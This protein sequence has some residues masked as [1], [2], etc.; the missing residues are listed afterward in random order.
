[1]SA[2]EHLLPW[3]QQPQEAAEP[4]IPV[5][6]LINLA[7][8]SLAVVNGPGVVVVP[9]GVQFRGNGSSRYA[10]RSVIFPFDWTAGFWLACLF[11]RRSTTPGAATYAIGSNA[12]SGNAFIG[13]R[14]PGAGATNRIEFG[15]RVSNGG[16]F[17]RIVTD[18][19]FTTSV[20]GIYCAVA[21]VPPNSVNTSSAYL[22]VNGVRHA[23]V[24]DLLNYTGTV[25]FGRFETIGAVRRNIGVDQFSDDGVFWAASGLGGI[26][27]QTAQRISAEMWAVFEPRR[28]WVPVSAG[29]GTTI[30]AGVGESTAAGSTADI[31]LGTTV[32]TGVGSAVADGSAASVSRGA[33]V[34]A[35]IGAA[36]AAGLDADIGTSA[37]EY[38]VGNAVA[39][40]ATASISLGTTV[41]ADVSNAVAAGSTAD[42]SLGTT[43]AAGVGNAVADGPSA[44]IT[45]GQTVSATVGDAVADGKTATITNDPVSTGIDLSFYGWDIFPEKLPEEKDSVR[46]Y[47]LDAVRDLSSKPIQKEVAKRATARILPP[48]VFV[49]RNLMVREIRLAVAEIVEAANEER[50]RKVRK[51]N[52]TIMLWM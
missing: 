21:V 26:D 13:L 25:A 33:T 36:V 52:E 12:S 39:D 35:S 20:G 23:T 49:P 50:R 31:S 34:N 16:S 11:E 4:S 29:G 38:Q 14:V 5:A 47:I 6:S 45:A 37:G 44:T 2:I 3:A 10:W 27:E 19:G 24:E 8:H 43:V 48:P 18:G 46:K 42:V 32:N 51:Y 17:G 15:L 28:I 40:G 22:Y 1:M 9:G 41:S 7:A 30:N